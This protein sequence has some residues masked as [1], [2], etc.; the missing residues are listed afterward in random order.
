M[1]SCWLSTWD[2]ANICWLLDL[3]VSFQG[4]LVYWE[5]PAKVSSRINAANTNI[6]V[7]IATF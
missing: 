7:F 3:L 1:T 6:W 4:F 5:K 2:Y